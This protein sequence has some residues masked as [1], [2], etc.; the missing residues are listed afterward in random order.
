MVYCPSIGYTPGSPRAYVRVTRWLASTGEWKTMAKLPLKGTSATSASYVDSSTIKDD[1]VRYAMRIINQDGTKQEAVT[2]TS[3]ATD[4]WQIGP[5]TPAIKS[6]TRT[7]PDK[8]TVRYLNPSWAATKIRLYLAASGDGGKTFGS[9]VLA[10]EFD[11]PARSATT[12]RT[13]TLTVSPT[14]T[15]KVQA[16]ARTTN[17][18]ELAAEA[19]ASFFPTV[20]KNVWSTPSIPSL[21][22]PF[23]DQLAGKVTFS[24]TP[25]P[26]DNTG[27][28]GAQVEHRPVGGSAT[29]ITV[30]GDETAAQTAAALATG[31]YE[32][33]ARTKHA[34]GQWSN[35][36]G[37][38]E[39]DVTT[40]PSLTIS[41]PD[42]GQT[43]PTNKPA[44]SLDWY[45]PSGATIA[46]WGARLKQGATVKES[47]SGKGPIS[48]LR[49]AAALADATSYTV[50]VWATA[51]N[52]LATPTDSVTFPVLYTRPGTPTAP[53][54][55][56]HEGEGVVA[57]AATYGASTTSTAIDRSVDD[58]DTWTRVGVG[59]GGT[60]TRTIQDQLAPTGL[61]GVLYRAV[62]ITNLGVEAYSSSV[63]VT[64]RPASDVW[65]VGADG[66]RC[67]VY[68][69]IR[70]DA[71][72]GQDVV[73]E[74][75]YGHDKPTAH[76]G[77]QRPVKIGISGTLRRGEGLEDDWA[78]LL[79]QPVHYRDPDGRHGWGT[80]D[81]TGVN[82]SSEWT[83]ERQ[84][85]ATWE[86]T[87][88]DPDDDGGQ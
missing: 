12:A 47:R 40:A 77:D 75:Y 5:K 44:F 53:S 17:P 6:V 74:Q 46:T 85:T 66:T 15:Y 72:L 56:W 82:Q 57:V 10:A 88:Y 26:T 48:S 71:S 3:S 81:A 36:S 54:A 33:R 78:G 45:S 28:S 41:Y 38:S 58:G 23:A 21:V 30:T 13:Y 84:I 1:R 16:A 42:D 22:A 79:G 49:F 76:Y 59:P 55:V 2:T 86:A 19:K 11:A 37:W 32:W 87:T 4:A 27:Q 8:I 63:A 20:L 34:S 83:E 35:W 52:A 60:G 9:G 14:L 50:E 29:T 51:S 62:A 39:F 64:T 18:P 24:W 25:K 65:L 69:N 70:L 68:S 80:L 67:R 43:V 7:A 61:V 31:S 73:T